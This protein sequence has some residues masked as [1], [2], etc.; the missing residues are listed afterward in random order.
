MPRGQTSA[1][2]TL[3]APWLRS[4]LGGLLVVGSVVGVLQ[5]L[6]AGA[7]TMT[8]LVATA[9]LVPGTAVGEGQLSQV[10]VPVHAVFEGALSPTDAG[11]SLFVTSP[12][13]AGSV[14]PRGSVSASPPTDD[15]IV[16]LELTVGTPAW[17]RA[18]ALAELWVASPEGANG[19]GAPFVVSPEVVVTAVFQ[20]DGFAAD[21]LSSRVDVLVP[22]RHLPSVIHALANG[23]F[24]SLTPVTGLGQ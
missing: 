18:G 5:T 12:V 16:T 10:S 24:M 23:F 6:N 7:T 17:L 9:P 3:R 2:R 22:R 13:A 21:S 4:A 8:V 11:G 1:P 14:V 20:D 15:S 19:F